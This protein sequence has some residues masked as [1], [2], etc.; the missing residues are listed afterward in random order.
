MLG[1]LRIYTIN[2]GDM[3]AFL[4]HFE[5]EV[6]PT[7]EKIGRPIVATW[8]NRR[9]NEFVWLRTFTDEADREAKQ[10]A[11]RDA[12]AA[13]GIQLGGNVAKME[14]RELEAAFPA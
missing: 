14:I 11:F 8:V 1:Q 2:K 4:K 9:Q 13:A 5:T 6:R 12:C 3:D 7:H 10:K